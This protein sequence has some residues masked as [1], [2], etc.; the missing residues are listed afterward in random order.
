MVV[1]PTVRAGCTD[2][3]RSCLGKCVHA[4]VRIIR[5]D[6]VTVLHEFICSILKALIRAGWGHGSGGQDL[7]VALLQTRRA[8]YT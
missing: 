7:V 1:I 4:V 3:V 2:P 6:V 5:H 8:Y